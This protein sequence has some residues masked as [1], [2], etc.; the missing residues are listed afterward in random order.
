M[1]EAGATESPGR[2]WGNEGGD[3]DATVTEGHFTTESEAVEELTAMGRQPLVLDM[4]SVDEEFHW[5]DFETFAFILEG[6]SSIE[7]EDGTRFD[8]GPGS[9]A[10]LPA[11]VMHRDI[12]GCTYRAVLGFSVD[13]ASM[14]QPVNKPAPVVL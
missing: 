3:M 12:P 11:G 2:R 4:V 5:H 1:Q 7:L 10:Y 14:T 8:A 13:L 6:T 9:R